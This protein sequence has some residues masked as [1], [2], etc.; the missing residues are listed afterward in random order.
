M[1]IVVNLGAVFFGVVLMV[2]VIKLVM[3]KRMTE[4]QSVLWLFMGIVAIILGIVPEV[5]KIIAAA[6]GIWYAPSILLLIACVV[7]LMIVFYN[8]IVI[9]K[10]TMEIQELALQVALLKDE[11]K[12]LKE[13]LEE[14][15]EER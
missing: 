12:E 10:N 5:I 13:K 7:L 9:S 1:S 3:E 8:S 6:L 4:A 14:K 11:N 15:L 2:I